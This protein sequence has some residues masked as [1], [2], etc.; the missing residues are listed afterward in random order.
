MKNPPKTAPSSL[1]F[2]ATGKGIIDKHAEFRGQFA[3]PAARER[4]KRFELNRISRVVIDQFDPE[5][6]SPSAKP[7]GLRDS[8]EIPYPTQKMQDDLIA[9]SGK[10]LSTSFVMVD[11]PEST[12]YVAVILE[13]TERGSLAFY[14]LVYNADNISK[15]VSGEMAG[16]FEGETRKQAR[17]EALE[18][19]KAEFGYEK[20]SE[21]L[22]KIS[23][24]GD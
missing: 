19:L 14:N 2:V 16:R 3:D 6:G 9:N 20:E 4:V 7:Y 1:S 8:D 5:S 17:E 24:S 15:N 21:N 12:F 18:M 22:E 23:G 10:P 11:R 13:R